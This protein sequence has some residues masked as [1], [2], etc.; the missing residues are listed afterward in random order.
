MS[1]KC[2]PASQERVEAVRKLKEELA[3]ALS[4][5]AAALSDVESQTALP[6][7]ESQTVFV[8]ESQTA[9][10]DVESHAK[11]S[12]TALE[13]GGQAEEVRALREELRVAR[14]SGTALGTGLPRSSA[15]VADASAGGG[16]PLGAAQRDISAGE[17]LSWRE[18]GPPNH[19]DDKVDGGCGETEAPARGESVG[20]ALSLRMALADIGEGLDAFKEEVRACSEKG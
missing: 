16:A 8:K 17:G 6:D 18:A 12:Q 10:S 14:A 5:R 7:V 2:E 19:H 13:G 11:E 9:L 4:D 15:T 20:F 3:A 1:L